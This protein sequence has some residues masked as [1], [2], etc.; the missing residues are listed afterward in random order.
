MQVVSGFVLMAGLHF[1]FMQKIKNTKQKYDAIFNKQVE[2]IAKNINNPKTN[3][4]LKQTWD[5]KQIEEKAKDFPAD[6][7]DLWI[8][9]I[10]HLQK[11]AWRVHSDACEKPTCSGCIG[12]VV[13]LY[14]HKKQAEF[15]SYDGHEGW[16]ITG[17]RWGK[18]DALVFSVICRLLGY[19]PLTNEL[20]ELPQNAWLVGLTFPM[21]RDILVPK[22]KSQMPK[23]SVN[24]SD[25]SVPWD[26]NKTDLI[27]SVFNGSE[28]GF[29][30]ADAG[31]EK[32]RGA[33]KQI[34]GFDEEPPEQVYSES[35]IRVEAGRDLVIRG[36]MTP[37]PFKG[38]TWTFHK[39]LKNTKRME[40]DKDLTI[41]TGS[42]HENPG[43]TASQ[44]KRMAA[45]RESWE[46][47][48]RFEGH[49]ISGLGRC[50]FDT[51]R[52]AEM[53]SKTADPVEVRPMLGGKM[54][55]WEE[56]D[57]KSGYVIG[58]DAAEGLEHGD[59]SVVHVLKRDT[60]P[61]LVC[62]YAGKM[63]PDELGKMAIGLAEEY[64]EAW[65]V[66]EMNNHGFTVMGQLRN[67]G[68]A[69]LY[70][71][72][73][74]DK[75]G[76]KESRRWGWHTNALTRPILVDEVARSIR[77]DAVEVPDINTLDEMGTFIIN[78]KGR[79][80]AQSGCADDRVIALGL[81]LQGHIRCPQYEPPVK[82][83]KEETIAGHS[84]A[85]MGV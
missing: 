83:L 48:V 77:E 11:Y 80:E 68:Y 30:S 34:I 37:D 5:P 70:T 57:K 3:P 36:A 4:Y 81:C 27:A 46:L 75:W 1:R 12:N 58:I 29:K 8:K 62:S 15:I 20:Y 54:F 19:N 44:K 13:R 31:I 9:S 16:V 2:L 10:V 49:Y 32:F 41:W 45:N 65:V 52:L 50:A 21:V 24:W 66:I 23:L 18:T 39:L 61:K 26:F 59:N 56:I 84:L 69:N 74:F 25:S 63:E 82:R 51:N 40:E 55:L 64:N 85:W 7:L 47:E 22:F 73:N 42:I 43:I 71:E 79:A 76:Q 53:R 6:I 38:L 17:N 14:F 72:K 35:T 33:G 28:C 67:Y 60:K 78:P